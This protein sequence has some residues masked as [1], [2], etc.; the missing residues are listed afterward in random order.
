M[1]VDVERQAWQ[2]FLA[3]FSERNKMRPTRLEVISKSGETETDFWLEAGL[4]LIGTSLDTNGEDAPHIEIMLD[5][6]GSHDVN[7]LTHAVARV[8]RVGYEAGDAGR[9]N[10]LEVE[11]EDGNMTILRFE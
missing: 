11:D 2:T 9:D 5:G 7:H 3:E 4:P 10:A 6:A 1:R 8:R